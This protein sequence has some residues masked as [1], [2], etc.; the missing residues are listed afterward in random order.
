MII[1]NYDSNGI[2]IGEDVADIDPMSPDN[3]LIPANATTIKPPQVENGS[4]PIWAGESWGI[5]TPEPMPA[6]TIDDWRKTAVISKKQ[7]WLN[8]ASAGLLDVIFSHMDALPRTDPL[9]IEFYESQ[10]YHRDNVLL[11]DF[12]TNVL[13]MT[14]EQI[15][16]LFLGVN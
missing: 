10:E 7:G 5:F 3:Y 13:N 16:M 9:R 6:P 8:L 12:C 4:F 11:N 14:V 2:F 15:D 1:Y